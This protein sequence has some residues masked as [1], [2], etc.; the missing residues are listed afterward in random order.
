MFKAELFNATAWASLFKESGAKVRSTA[1][2]GHTRPDLT[3]VPHTSRR[4]L[5]QYI[6][7]TSKHHEGYTNWPSAQR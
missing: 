6:V 5:V 3:L 7:L 4:S 1:G 2:V